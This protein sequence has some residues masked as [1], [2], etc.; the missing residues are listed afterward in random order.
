[1]FFIL[2]PILSLQFVISKL[3]TAQLLTVVRTYPYKSK[4]CSVFHHVR[5]VFREVLSILRR[6]GEREERKFSISQSTKYCT[7][8]WKGGEPVFWWKSKENCSCCLHF[9]FRYFIFTSCT[10][11]LWIT[12][13]IHVNFMRVANFHISFWLQCAEMLQAKVVL[14]CLLIPLLLCRQPCR[15]ILWWI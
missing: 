12:R 13:Y 5:Q 6:N 3:T 9:Q 8:R 14:W 2:L 15:K 4:V 10:L 11:F 1:M 7:L